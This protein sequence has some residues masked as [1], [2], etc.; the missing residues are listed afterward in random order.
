MFV[1]PLFV[2]LP[3]KGTLLRAVACLRKCA[4]ACVRACVCVRAREKQKPERNGRQYTVRERERW[5][6]G[7]VRVCAIEQPPVMRGSML[8][9]MVSNT[10]WGNSSFTPRLKPS[11][12]FCLPSSVNISLSPGTDSGVNRNQ[13]MHTNTSPRI[14]SNL[15]VS[16]S[17]SH[18]NCPLPLVGLSLS[19]LDYPAE[20]L[21]ITELFVNAECLCV[22]LS[23]LA[24]LPVLIIAL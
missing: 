5:E 24:R 10:A 19:I 3:S 9:R 11:S 1:F 7:G 4:D 17:S 23:S 2:Y 16:L 14:S 8:T 12:L 15:S 20:F 21:S 13:I 18:T 22:L 6:G